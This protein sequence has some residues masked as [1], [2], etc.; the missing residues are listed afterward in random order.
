[1]KSLLLFQFVLLI[2]GKETL[3]EEE[4]SD[5]FGTDTD[6]LNQAFVETTN[7][8]PTRKQ[9]AT[10][11]ADFLTTSGSVTCL[12][13]YSYSG[14]MKTYTHTFRLNYQGMIEL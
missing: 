9:V 2:L 8:D 13:K 5:S 12:Y 1:L 6:R 14:E 11:P 7:T 3:S 10:Y 4:W